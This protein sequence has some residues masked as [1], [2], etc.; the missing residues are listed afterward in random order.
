MPRQPLLG[1][2]VHYA[3]Y[4][5]SLCLE[6]AAKVTLKP[7]LRTY[8][9]EQEYISFM[10][11]SIGTQNAEQIRDF[12]LSRWKAKCR[13]IEAAPYSPACQ[14]LLKMQCTT[15]LLSCLQGVLNTMVMAHIYCNNLDRE[16]DHDAIDKYAKSLPPLPDSYFDVLQGVSELS[17]PRCCYSEEYAQVMFPFAFPPKGPQALARI[18]GTDKG[19]QFDLTSA[20]IALSQITTNAQP[21]NAEQFSKIAEPYRTYLKKQNDTLLAQLEAAKK[22]DGSYTVNTLPDSIKNE[23]VLPTILAKFKGH[24]LLVDIWATWCGPC[25]QANQELAPYKAQ[26]QQQGIVFV[27]I[28][29]ETSPLNRWKIMIPDLHGQHFRVTDAQWKYLYKALKIGGVPTYLFVDKEG[30]IKEQ[31]TGYPGAETIRDKALNLTKQ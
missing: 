3:G 13:Q 21:L 25:R 26:M 30:H 15:D 18:L 1:A 31:Q 29:G 19:F 12:Y 2:P 5:A 10:K 27:Y 24:P 28:T 7:A 8:R 20:Y 9:T 14:T 4:L 16:K 23:D 6:M 22:S 17:D 11:D